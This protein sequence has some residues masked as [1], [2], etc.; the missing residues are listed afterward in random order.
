[1]RAG[2]GDR[3]AR[4]T[5]SG[6]PARG[7]GPSTPDLAICRAITSLGDRRSCSDTISQSMGQRPTSRRGI[8]CGAD[9]WQPV[10]KAPLHSTV[11]ASVTTWGCAPNPRRPLAG[12]PSPRAASAEAHCVRLGGRLHECSS[13]P[14][15]SCVARRSHMVEYARFSRLVPAGRGIDTGGSRCD[16]GFHHGLQ[17]G[18]FVFQ[19]GAGSRRLGGKPLAPTQSVAALGEQ[20]PSGKGTDSARIPVS[21]T[22]SRARTGPTA[23]SGSAA[24]RSRS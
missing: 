14:F 1:M 8:S 21:C 18:R 12:T 24:S 7:S 6:G 11:H 17:A 2:D 3:S 23:S 16:A 13:S 15:L 20:A 10:A 4:I 5:V 9:S 19:S 22:S